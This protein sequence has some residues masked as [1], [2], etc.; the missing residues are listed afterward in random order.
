MAVKEIIGG[1][2]DKDSFEVSEPSRRELSEK[3]FN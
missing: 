3:K 2:G 1:K